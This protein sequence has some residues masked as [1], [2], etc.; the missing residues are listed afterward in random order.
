MRVVVFSD[1]HGNLT[2]LEAVLADIERQPA[3]DAV[4][5]AGDACLF[6]PRPGA[7]ASRI[8]ESV[9]A[10]VFG[11]TDEWIDRPLPL[12]EAA[13]AA[14]QERVRFIQAMAAWTQAQMD[15]AGLQWLRSL[16]FEQRLS[17]TGNPQDDLLIVHANPRDVMGVI[18]P[19]E[20]IQTS[21]MGGLKQTDEALAA[22][23]AGTPAGAIAFG[24]LHFPNVR[25]WGSVLLA[26][27]S[28]VSLPGDGDPRAKYG[29]LTWDGRHW[30]VTHHYV[31]YDIEAEIAAFETAQPPDWEAA[32]KQLAA[33]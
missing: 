29:L 3:L 5:F 28:S 31:P 33:N 22:M 17:P 24:H 27:I 15:P 13:P 14:T 1:V 30:S 20:S 8:R 19:P 2:A 7:C 10:A 21:R 16:P 25:Y 9:T 23:L 18:Y 12:D 32:V 4:I 11:N 26:N 6:G